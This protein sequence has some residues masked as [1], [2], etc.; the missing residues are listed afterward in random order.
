MFWDTVY[1]QSSCKL[2]HESFGDLYLLNFRANSVKFWWS[3]DP[4][5][6]LAIFDMETLLARYLENY[7]S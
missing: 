5:Q 3:Y 6:F 2:G 4:L 7:L 1:K